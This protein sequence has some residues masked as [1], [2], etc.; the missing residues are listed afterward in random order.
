[1]TLVRYAAVLS[2]ILSGRILAAGPTTLDRVRTAGV[3]SCGLV[4][5]EPEYSNLD[6]HGNRA[7]FDVDLCKAVAVAVLGNGAHFNVTPFPDETRALEA[8]HK[9]VIDLIPTATPT[10]V[11]EAGKHFAFSPPVLRDYQAFMI[12]AASG[13]HT[14]QDLAGKKICYLAETD[15]EVRMQHFVRERKLATIPFPFQEEGEM[16]A[17]F[18]TNNCA[19]ISADVTQ[20]AYERI[21]FRHTARSYVFLPD[22]IAEDPLAPATRL[23][24][25]QW[26]ALVSEVTGTLAQ[27]ERL[28]IT[29]ANIDAMT[30][31]NDPTIVRM[32]HPAVAPELSAGLTG[33][34]TAR[35][36]KAVGNYGEIYTRDLGEHS[37]M[38]LSRQATPLPPASADL[39]AASSPTR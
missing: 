21:A 31:S 13:L 7:A 24:D 10:F 2:L 29:Q 11:S 25:P 34:W 15:I 39:I 23:D 37:P 30:A 1:M 5:E 18:I 4:T 16:E 26:T 20:L 38:R 28:N 8:L 22:I 17:A 36:I 35:V 6:A 12:D 33:D 3:L 19:A 27:A 14:A 32:L 9:G